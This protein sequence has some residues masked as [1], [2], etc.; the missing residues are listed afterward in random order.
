M[1]R[2]TSFAAD[3][4]LALHTIMD[5]QLA[6]A[7]GSSYVDLA[8]FAIDVDRVYWLAPED[9]RLPFGW[10]VLLTEHYLLRWCETH[11]ALR[12]ELLEAICAPL[13]QERPGEPPLG[14]QIV[15]AVYDALVRGALPDELRNLFASWRHAPRELLHALHELRESGRATLKR[16]AVHCLSV[17]LQPPL[18]ATTRE[19]LEQIC[20]A[21][22]P[23]ASGSEPAAASV[24]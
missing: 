22:Q 8:A 12:H 10:E 23:Q 11:V 6:A 14:G 24:R 9:E 5:P 17:D 7:H 15:F 3:D 4:M 18:A 2:R 13:L 16:L 1:N 19:T 21:E 20:F